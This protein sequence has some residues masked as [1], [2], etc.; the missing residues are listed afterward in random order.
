[1]MISAHMGLISR[2]ARKWE[3]SGEKTP[4]KPGSRTWVVSHEPPVGLNPHTW[5]DVRNRK[6][7]IQLLNL[8]TCNVDLE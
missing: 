1:M 3:H 7:K 4:G 2:W 8:F 5:P 6:K